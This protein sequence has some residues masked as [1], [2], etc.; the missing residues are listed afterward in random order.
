[1]IMFY[2]LLNGEQRTFRIV[3]YSSNRKYGSF[4]SMW[5][6]FIGGINLYYRADCM[7]LGT[8]P[9]NRVDSYGINFIFAEN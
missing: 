2:K 5:L 1:M 9:A 7:K 8:D 3:K 4:T 6:I